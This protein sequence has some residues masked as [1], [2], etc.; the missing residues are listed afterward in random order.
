MCG[1]VGERSVTSCGTWEQKKRFLG[2]T[3]FF[4]SLF[5]RGLPRPLFG[6]QERSASCLIRFFFAF[7]SLR[8]LTLFQS[9]KSFIARF[10]SEAVFSN[11]SFS[12]TTCSSFISSSIRCILR[13]FPSSILLIIPNNCLTSRLSLSGASTGQ[14]SWQFWRICLGSMATIPRQRTFF[15]KHHIQKH[16]PP[17]DKTNTWARSLH[18]Q[19]QSW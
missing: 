11:T 14:F 4:S 13:S 6:R 15:A 19:L 5:L 16:P 17:L 1:D 7:L 9:P 10:R 8:D 12:D 3:R 2:K 18:L